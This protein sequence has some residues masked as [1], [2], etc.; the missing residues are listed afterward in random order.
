MLWSKSLPENICGNF[1]SR[2]RILQIAGKIAKH[3]KIRTCK[4]FRSTPTS[5][6]G[7][8]P[9]KR[10]KAL[11]TRLV[12][13]GI[14]TVSL[15]CCVLTSYNGSAVHPVNW[16]SPLTAEPPCARRPITKKNWS[17]ITENLLLTSPY[18]LCG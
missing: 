15:R 12:S 6:P 17:S 7:F 11:G 4:N 3:A 9:S 1:Y 13:H 8:F 10:E 14:S 18:G 16:N 5:S 2:K